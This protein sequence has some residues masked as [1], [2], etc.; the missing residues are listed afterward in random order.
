MRMGVNA[1]GYTVVHM[2]QKEKSNCL[3][4]FKNKPTSSKMIP[5]GRGRVTVMMRLAFKIFSK[6]KVTGGSVLFILPTLIR[7]LSPGAP[8]ST[9]MGV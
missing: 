2:K 9:A 1:D 4:T 5:M 6:T 8:S 3:F 7:T